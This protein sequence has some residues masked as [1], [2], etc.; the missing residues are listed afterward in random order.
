VTSIY[1]GGARI[2]DLGGQIEKKKFEG[3][4]IIKITKFRDKIN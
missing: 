1:R 4:K 2:Q 3:A